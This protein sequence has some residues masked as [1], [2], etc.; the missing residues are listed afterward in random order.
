MFAVESSA[1]FA[2]TQF[3]EGNALLEN[4]RYGEQ[5]KTTTRRTAFNFKVS[6]LFYKLYTPESFIVLFFTTKVSTLISVEGVQTLPR[7]PN[8]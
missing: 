3:S 8:S 6:R 7:S 1:Y 4:F 5:T 2:R